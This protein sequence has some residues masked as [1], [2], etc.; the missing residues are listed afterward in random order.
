MA[1]SYSPASSPIPAATPAAGTPARWAE[2]AILIPQT[3]AR[4]PAPATMARPALSAEP[5]AATI[6]QTPC[7]A[8][9]AAGAGAIP[10]RPAP[11]QARPPAAPAGAMAA[12]AATAAT[13]AIPAAAAAATPRR[14]NGALGRPTWWP[15]ENRSR[16]D[17]LP[18]LALSKR[19]RH[20]ILILIQNRR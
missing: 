19:V 18:A 12:T 15:S 13:A 17:F 8:A 14:N 16:Q 7:A 3:A 6:L 5:A 2:R 9:A 10:A 11:S 4:A 1:V 20:G